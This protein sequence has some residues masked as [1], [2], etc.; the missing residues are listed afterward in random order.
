MFFFTFKM[1]NL[2]VTGE[3]ARISADGTN[4]GCFRGGTEG[5]LAISD[6]K[7][8]EEEEG[9]GLHGDDNSENCFALTFR[10]LFIPE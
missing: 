6:A 5:V 2:S 8:G 9:E 3:A 10:V 4:K 7:E 1:S